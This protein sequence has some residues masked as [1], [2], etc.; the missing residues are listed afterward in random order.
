LALR[1]VIEPPEHPRRYSGAA[2]PT[3]AKRVV[4]NC[5]YYLR[6]AILSNDTQRTFHRKMTDLCLKNCSKRLLSL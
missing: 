6:M 2:Q 4:A 3:I 1:K 5:E